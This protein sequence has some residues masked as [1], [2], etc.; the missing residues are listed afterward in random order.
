MPQLVVY[1]RRGTIRETTKQ[2]KLLNEMSQVVADTLGFETNQVGGLWIVPSVIADE[3]QLHVN[4]EFSASIWNF[5]KYLKW[6]SLVQEK[7]T[8]YLQGS[9]LVPENTMVGVWVRPKWE[10]SFNAFIKMW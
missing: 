1:C 9:N 6:V 10:A 5:W 3:V 7:L 4:V 8:E 2:N